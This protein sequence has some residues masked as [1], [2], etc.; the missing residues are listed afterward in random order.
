MLKIHEHQID[1]IIGS[2]LAYDKEDVKLLMKTLGHA[3]IVH[4]KLKIMISFQKN[5]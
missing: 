3:M 2:E 4:P 1:T 5:K